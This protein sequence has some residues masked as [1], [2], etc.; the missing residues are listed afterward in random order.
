[1]KTAESYSP[2]PSG[3]KGFG[4][5]GMVSTLGKVGALAGSADGVLNVGSVPEFGDA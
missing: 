2:S 3:E 4:Q 5:V 1:M